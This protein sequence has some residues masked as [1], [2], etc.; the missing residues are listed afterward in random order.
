MSNFHNLTIE[1]CLK[2]LKTKP[3]GLT[4]KEVQKRIKKYGFNKLEKENH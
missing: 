2:E 3:E 4:Q 1:A